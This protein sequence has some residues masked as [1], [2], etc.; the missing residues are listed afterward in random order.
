MLVFII[1]LALIAILLF[2]ELGNPMLRD[3]GASVSWLC[4]FILRNFIM[5]S[6]AKGVEIYTISYLCLRRNVSGR[7]FGPNFALL[8]VQSR[9]YPAVLLA[10][11]FISLLH[12][13]GVQRLCQTL[14]ILP[15]CNKG[16]QCEQSSWERVGK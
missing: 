13:V 15:E 6:M 12:A 14:V 5:F 9:G 7:L 1:P 3:T 8:V 11:G 10:Y 16:M 4:L 2:Y